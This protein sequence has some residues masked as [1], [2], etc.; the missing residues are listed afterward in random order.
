[1]T[2]YYKIGANK[3]F[4]VNTADGNIVSSYTN[5]SD[6]SQYTSTTAELSAGITYY[7]YVDSS[8]AEFYGAVVTPKESTVST[9]PP[10][11]VVPTSQ[12]VESSLPTASP[13]N[14]PTQQPEASASPLPVQNTQFKMDGQIIN[15]LKNGAIDIE[16]ITPSD[17]TTVY[18]TSYDNYGRVISILIAETKN[19]SFNQSINIGD[20]IKNIKVFMWND[21]LP[22]TQCAQ[23]SK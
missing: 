10:E 23:I 13:E 9:A 11:T 16:G 17:D 6:A 18:I 4:K 5:K 15:T 8:K 12:P 14:T 3:T 1:M 7:F 22:E 19:R 21:T 2:V 20:N